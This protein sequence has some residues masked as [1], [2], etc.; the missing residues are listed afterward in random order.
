L[1]NN[2]VS[3]AIFVLISFLYIYLWSVLHNKFISLYFKTLFFRFFLF[4]FYN[5]YNID[6]N[7]NCWLS[8]MEKI[9]FV[10][11]IVGNP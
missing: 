7:Q 5:Y 1:K 4:E 3:V 11:S 2:F 6:K 10:L 8:K 9:F